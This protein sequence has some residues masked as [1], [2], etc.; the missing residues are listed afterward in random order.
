MKLSEEWQQRLTPTD[1]LVCKLVNH[2]AFGMSVNFV[3]FMNVVVLAIQA[4]HSVTRAREGKEASALFLLFDLIFC[5]F[6]CTEITL[7]L[8]GDRIVFFVGPD[9]KWN[10]MDAS[11]VPLDVV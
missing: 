3:I 8:L 2:R 6:F 1:G 9:A 10:I 5:A 7:R 4:E 11:F